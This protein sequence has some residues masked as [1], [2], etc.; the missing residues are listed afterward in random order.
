MGKIRQSRKDLPSRVY[1]KHGAYYFVNL[2]NKWIPLGKDYGLAMQKW[3]SMLE[4]PVGKQRMGA[5]MDAYILEELPNKKAR[6][7]EEYLASIKM[8]RP[9]F[10]NMWPEDVE[11]KDIYAFMRLRGAPI[12]VNRDV[13]VLSNVMNHAVKMG[14]VNLNPCKQVRRNPSAARSREVLDSEIVALL[15]HCPTW[16]QCYIKLKLLTGLRQGDMLNIRLDQLRDEGLY[17]E[18][19]KTGKRLLFAWDDNLHNSINDIKALRHRVT[20]LY[21]FNNP[22]DGMPMSQSSFKGHWRKIMVAA[23]KAGS[24]I[25]RFAENDLRA[26]VATEAQGLGQ[27][28]SAML[29]HSSDAVTR[30]HYIRGTQTV[31]PLGKKY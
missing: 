26:K 16:L 2:A 21:L 7:Q 11:P 9:V 12:S 17:V 3:A 8:L 6:T 1:F 27:N 13:A 24:I 20:S 25:E 30:R 4:P 14:L 15:L 5:V 22:R 28:A 19:S 23:M 10:A 29:G 18:T 31:T